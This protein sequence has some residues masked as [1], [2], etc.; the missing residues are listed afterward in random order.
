[1]S[2]ML[3]SDLNNPNF[4]GA[5]NPDSMLSAEFYWHEPEDVHKSE[6]A[7]KI[8]RLPKMPYV[9]IQNPGDHTSIMETPVTERHKKRWPEK[10]L[11]FQIENNMIEGAAEIPGWKI[12]E[13]T[14]LNPE[15]VRQLKFMRFTVVEQ[16]ANASDAQCQNIGMDGMSLREKARLALR[17]RLGVE[18]KQEMDA[19]SAEISSLREENKELKEKFAKFEAFMAASSPEKEASTEEAPKRRGRPPKTEVDTEEFNEHHG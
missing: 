3:A 2:A 6:A 18:I 16:I 10:W 4:V 9:R 5:V 19:K 15:Q 12:E 11:Y 8:V 13:W 14:H 17:A 1:M 7:G